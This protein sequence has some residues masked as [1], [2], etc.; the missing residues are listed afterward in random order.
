VW[1]AGIDGPGQTLAIA[2]TKLVD[3]SDGVTFRQ[4][5]G[6]P[7][8]TTPQQINAYGSARGCTTTD[9]NSVCKIDDMV[10]H[11]SG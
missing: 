8:G 2:G 9:L 4:Y 10:K 5:F 1:T 11:S 6:L 7:S 3:L